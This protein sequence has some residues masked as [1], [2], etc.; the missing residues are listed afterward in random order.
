MTEFRIRDTIK[1]QIVRELIE[2]YYIE[3]IQTKIK[4]KKC[5]KRTGQIF[6]TTS[7]VLVAIGSILSFSSGYFKDST[8]SFFAGSISTLSLA[9]LQFASFAYMENK[10]QSHELNILLKKLDLDVVPIL[11]SSN[12]S[13]QNSSIQQI[14]QYERVEQ[15]EPDHS[16]PTKS[17]EVKEV[18]V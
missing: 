8:L 13:I 10:R 3:D 5:W 6:E 7:K 9:T 16:V 11:E 18:M 15:L 17:E 2:P 4:G 12:S 14:Q 1:S